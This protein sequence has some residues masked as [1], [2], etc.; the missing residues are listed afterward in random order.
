[1]L[2]EVK[3]AYNSD[4]DKSLSDSIYWSSYKG[5]YKKTI[6]DGAEKG[7]NYVVFGN[8]EYFNLS[9]Y[10]TCKFSDKSLYVKFEIVTQ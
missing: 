7:A 5:L 6:M 4:A 10:S 3:Q 1:M 2:R 8:M 9:N